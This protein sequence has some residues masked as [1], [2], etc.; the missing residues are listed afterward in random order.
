MYVFIV[1]DTA[2]EAIRQYQR[3]FNKLWFYDICKD[4]IKERTSPSRGSNVNQPCCN[5]N[6]YRIPTAKARR[7]IRRSR[8]TSWRNYV[9]KMNS[10][11]SFKSVWNR[12]R[13]I[14]G[15]ASSNS[16]HHVSYLYVT[17]LKSRILTFHQKML[18]YTIGLSL[19][20]SYRMLYIE[21]MILQ[22]DQMKYIINF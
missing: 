4:A 7:D 9:S 20:R 2:E 21:S 12:I 19:L 1:K 8:K 18:K 15:K 22:Q 10:Q 5:L 6:A 3:R 16:I 11:I 17:N 13:K 14:K